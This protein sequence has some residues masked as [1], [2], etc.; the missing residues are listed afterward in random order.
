M[1]TMD[2]ISLLEKCLFEGRRDRKESRTA[3]G[4][5]AFY[6]DG[7]LELFGHKYAPFFKTREEE[8][9]R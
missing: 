4:L 9:R 2:L 6:K 5:P 8:L 7:I 3:V 1:C